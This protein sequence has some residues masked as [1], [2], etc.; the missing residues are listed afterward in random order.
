MTER[1]IRG[2]LSL[3]DTEVSQ[4]RGSLHV[5][6][7]RRNGFRRVRKCFKISVSLTVGV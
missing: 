2:G 4:S 6:K 5:T 1:K 3:F 7:M